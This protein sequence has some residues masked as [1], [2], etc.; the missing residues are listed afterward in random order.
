MSNAGIRRR[1][2]TQF[3]GV[4]C[5]ALLFAALAGCGGD[6]SAGFAGS[7]TLEA[8]EVTVAAQTA[9]Q[10]L[11]LSRDEGDAV[12]A[13]DTLATIDV[14]KLMLQRRQLL[15]SVD[16][17]RANRRPVAETVRQATDNLE[18]IEKSYRRINALFEQGTATQQQRDDAHTKYQVAQSQLESAK[19]QGA[20]LDAREATVRASIAL[21]DRQ[22]RDGDVIAP[23][24]GVITEKYV[25]SGE[26]VGAGSAVFKIA[27][28]KRF[29]IKV[30]VSERDL[31]LFAV[32]SVAQVRV[33]A[34]PEPLSGAV[35][36][37]SPQA[38]FTPKNV[39][40]K[41]ARAELVYAVKVTIEN[42]P[43]VLKIGMPA[44][45]HLK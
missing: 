20:M 15:A 37:V 36:W 23:L 2:A 26:I 34:H 4:V 12:A 9:G 31:G 29:W 40:T 28:T 19:A 11:R 42:P 44:E 41:D 14:E 6:K 32:G 17:I 10:I 7:G 43:G 39:E 3:P 30:Y 22:I 25:E 13:G 8:T 21:L 45:V 5:G 16:E 38:E 18:N 1:V 27:D 24:A 35:S 33:D